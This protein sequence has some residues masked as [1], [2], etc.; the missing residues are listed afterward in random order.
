M[1]VFYNSMIV[2]SRWVIRM[3]FEKITLAIVGGILIFVY[4]INFITNGFEVSSSI[5]VVTTEMFFAGV[6]IIVLCILERAASSEAK[7]MLIAKI[8]HVHIKTWKII[9][10][11]RPKVLLVT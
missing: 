1:V 3:S 5:E 4:I 7:V 10:I 2:Q 6:L 9:E 11:N 8:W